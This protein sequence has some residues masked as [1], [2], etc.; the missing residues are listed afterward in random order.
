MVAVG[1]RWVPPERPR[2]CLAPW[3][4]LFR[5]PAPGRTARARG[6]AVTLTGAAEIC[7]ESA[8]VVPVPRWAQC[9]APHASWHARAMTTLRIST[10]PAELDLGMI[11]RFLAEQSTW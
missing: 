9:T 4:A 6:Q 3:Q 7:S 2:R 10:D 5:A 1:G 11:H 8:D